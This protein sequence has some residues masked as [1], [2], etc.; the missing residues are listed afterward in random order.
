MGRGVLL[1][2]DEGLRLQEGCHCCIR[3]FSNK[4]VRSL[5]YC[6]IA[7]YHRNE[8]LEFNLDN[9]KAKVLFR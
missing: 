1:P 5:M 4:F 2:L 3:L 7:S 6:L 9:E 8:V